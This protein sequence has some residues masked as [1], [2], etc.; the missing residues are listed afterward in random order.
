MRVGE[1]D[2]VYLFYRPFRRYQDLRPLV[3]A[4]HGFSGTAGGMAESSQLHELAKKHG[5]YLA[6]PDGDPTWKLF[7]PG[8][9]DESPD[10]TFFDQLV[11]QL[12]DRYPIDRQRVYVVGMSRGGDFA[13]YLAERRS[14]E[15]AAVVS[16][17]ACVEQVGVCQRPFPV[18]FI[19]GTKDDRVPPQ[20]FPATPDAMRLAGHP[21]EVLRPV[22]VGHRW[23][24]PLN[25]QVWAF[26]ARHRLD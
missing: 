4:Y 9:L 2:R 15:V 1:T 18:L 8:G 24:V 12:S 16:Q 14:T 23:H 10:L 17:G 22:G 25:D 11:D 3:L 21:V 20:R 6:Y 5:F 19:V 26:L 13:I 7:V